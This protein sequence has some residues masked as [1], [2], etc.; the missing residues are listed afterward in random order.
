MTV[1]RFLR[2]FLEATRLVPKA[3]AIAVAG[4]MMGPVDRQRLA[5]LAAGSDRC[6][7]RD[8]VQDIPAL[9]AAADVV[10]TMCGY[11]TAAELMALRRRAIVVPRNWRFGEHGKGTAPGYELEQSLRARALVELGIADLIPPDQ[12]SPERLSQ[13]IRAAL[14]A[15]RG[16]APERPDMTGA[17]QAADHILALALQARAA[18]AAA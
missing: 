7:L 16:V 15:P 13:R 14:D 4:P 1:I 12:L 10:V 11:N 6:V 3:S 8:V 9:M 17:S 2:D 5:H 18:D